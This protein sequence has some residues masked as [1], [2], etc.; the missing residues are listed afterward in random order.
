MMRLLIV[1]CIRIDFSI[2]STS[3]SLTNL[4]IVFI[5]H[6]ISGIDVVSALQTVSL[7]LIYFMGL[8]MAH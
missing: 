7:I 3:V 5:A 6:L 4:R 8:L 2:D 1:S